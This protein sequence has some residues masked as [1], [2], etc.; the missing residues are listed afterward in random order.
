[1]NNILLGFSL[2]SGVF[3]SGLFIG[4]MLVEYRDHEGYVSGDTVLMCILSVGLILLGAL[5]PH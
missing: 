4:M 2:Y 3:F 1:M 5:W